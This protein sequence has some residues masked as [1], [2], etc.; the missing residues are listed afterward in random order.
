[1]NYFCRLMQIPKWVRLFLS[2]I[3]IGI[4][5]PLFLTP[6]PGGFLIATAGG[7][8]LFCA[9][10]SMR[11][12]LRK[13]VGRFPK[14]AH[15]LEPLFHSC[16]ICAN[17]CHESAPAGVLSPPPVSGTETDSETPPRGMAVQPSRTSRR[18]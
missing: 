13:G 17:T 1:M 5:L 3:L 9:S 2:W 12:R 16:D 8:M 6:I 11:N 14:L 15:R 4:G 7:M 18:P 10:P